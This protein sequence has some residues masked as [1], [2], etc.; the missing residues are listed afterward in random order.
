[1]HSRIN[2]D[3]CL[4]REGYTDA[5]SSYIILSDATGTRT[6]FS[7]YGLPEMTVQELTDIVETFSPEDEYIFHFEV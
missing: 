5:A 3:R 2:F 6:L 4:F 7:Y 1:M